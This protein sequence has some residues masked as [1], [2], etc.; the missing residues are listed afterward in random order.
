M[1]YARIS[2]DFSPGIWRLDSESE[3]DC[4]LRNEAVGRVASGCIV[5]P[6]MQIWTTY[7][8]YGLTR[9]LALN[10]SAER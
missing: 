10:P 3:M 9:T 7:Y 2:F 5:N 8:L 1:R 4:E 6:R